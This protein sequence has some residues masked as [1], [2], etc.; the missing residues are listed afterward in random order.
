MA[1]IIRNKI[2]EF[3]NFQEFFK[4][5][6]PN[7]LKLLGFIFIFIGQLA[8][9]I[10]SKGKYIIDPFGLGITVMAFGSITNFNP[11]PSCHQNG[12]MFRLMS[13]F[14]LTK[15]M[16]Q[17]ILAWLNKYK[18]DEE[19]NKD[20]DKYM[21]T[22]IL[23][24]MGFAF[25]MLGAWNQIT[26]CG[27]NLLS[28]PFPIG[29]TAMFFSM[30]LYTVGIVDSWVPYQTMNFFIITKFMSHVTHAGHSELDIWGI[31]HEHNEHNKDDNFY[32][33]LYKLYNLFE[34]KNKEQTAQSVVPVQ[35]PVQ[36]VVQVQPLVNEQFQSAGNVFR[37][38]NN[39]I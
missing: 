7:I 12:S 17:P 29:V 13:I 8:K 19:K 27:G 38:Y 39:L 1:M 31:K 18:N 34:I 6:T 32:N 14:I 30:L 23:K 16:S 24:C 15:L 9:I 22:N 5:F 3:F 20:R 35:P 11:K 10:I 36:S 33:K 21:A 37:G 26:N 25:V 28:D 2:Q 4:I